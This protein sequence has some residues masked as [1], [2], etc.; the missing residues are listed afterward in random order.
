M[1]FIPKLYLSIGV[2]LD[3][4]FPR[5]RNVVFFIWNVVTKSINKTQMSSQLDPTLTA[6]LIT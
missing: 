2:I 3:V 6:I 4:L 1:V 5:E